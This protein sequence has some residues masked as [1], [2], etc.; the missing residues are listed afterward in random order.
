MKPEH[1]LIASAYMSIVG[2]RVHLFI[3]SVYPSSM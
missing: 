1:V 2:D 3:T